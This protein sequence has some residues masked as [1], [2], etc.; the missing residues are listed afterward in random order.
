[1]APIADATPPMA[2]SRISAVRRPSHHATDPA[3]SADSSSATCSG[4]PV[5]SVPNRTMVRPMI[6]I[7]SRITKTDCANVGWRAG[8][9]EAGLSAT[10]HARSVST[11]HDSADL[12]QR[13]DGGAFVGSLHKVDGG[14]DL[15]A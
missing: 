14:L 2:A 1:M 5:A 9:T 12:G 8:L 7:S 11:G 6:A 15:G 10:R 13:A 3:P 4:P